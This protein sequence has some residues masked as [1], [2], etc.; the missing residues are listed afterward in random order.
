[1]ERPAHLPQPGFFHGRPRPT[2]EK[3]FVVMMSACLGGVGCGVDGSTNGDHRDL[4]SWLFRPAVRIVK[5]CPEDFSFGTPRMTPDS[6]GGNGFDVLDGK[7]S[8]LAEDGTDWTAGMVK[9]AYAMRD[10]ALKEQVELAIL[11]DIS[12]ACGSTVTYLGS[13]LAENKV[14][15]QGPGV[16]AAALIRAGIPVTSQR[17]DRSLRILRDW[18]DGTRMLTDERDHWEKEWYQGYFGRRP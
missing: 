2:A 18:L 16:A 4:R 5:F 1:M 8:S 9:A 12:G 11:M 13:R 6:H 7:A 3:P 17:D 14:Y 15:Q 10:L